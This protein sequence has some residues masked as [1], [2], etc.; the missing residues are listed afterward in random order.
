MKTTPPLAHVPYRVIVRMAM[1][2]RKESRPGK[3]E[4]VGR[5]NRSSARAVFDLYW[6]R[7]WR[8]AAQ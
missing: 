1:A 6:A 3:K 8:E 5:D 7:K 4:R 2:E